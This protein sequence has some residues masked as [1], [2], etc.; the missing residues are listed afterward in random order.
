MY[1]MCNLKAPFRANNSE[2]LGKMIKRGQF[3]AIRQPYSKKLV[4]IISKC[5]KVRNRANM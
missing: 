3:E 2:N 4:N 1:E 5:L